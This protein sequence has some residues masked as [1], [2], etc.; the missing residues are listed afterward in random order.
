MSALVEACS[1][2]RQAL[3]QDTDPAS[4]VT[5]LPELTRQATI[6]EAVRLELVRRLAQSDCWAGSGAASA[7]GWLRRET[8]VDGARAHCDVRT[9]LGLRQTPVLAAAFG[10]GD[11]SRAHVD[12]VLRT[13]LATA[14]RAGALPVAETAITVA[15]TRCCPKDLNRLMLTWADQVDPQS[16]HETEIHAHQRRYLHCSQVGDGWAIDGFVGNEQGT[17]IATALNAEMAEL[18]DKS[19]TAR[20]DLTPRQRRADALY[21]LAR[22]ANTSLPPSN[23]LPPTVMITVPLARLRGEPGQHP[24]AT[25][26]VTNGSGDTVISTETAR[27]LSCDAN[28]QRIVID[29]QGLPLD[30]GRATRTIPA[31]IRKALIIRDQ[32]CAYK[33]CDRPHGW[34]QAHHI[35]HWANAGPT[36]LHNLVLLCQHHHHALHDQALN[37]TG[38]T[39][40]WI[41]GR[42]QIGQRPNLE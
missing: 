36:A 24:S 40:T 39:V 23:G 20:T 18:R 3:T 34:C 13:A 16:T 14:L 17:E 32:G 30:I 9:A 22:E 4:T 31:H 11:L 41:N 42:P 2:L 26:Q 12:T 21:Q 33:G 5:V 35:T 29:P 7:A 6:L 27:R 37:D 19:P 28:I 25:L 1:A 38:A 15:A 8:R 10:N